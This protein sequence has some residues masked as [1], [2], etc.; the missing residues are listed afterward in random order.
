MVKDMGNLRGIPSKGRSGDR[1]GHCG[2]FPNTLVGLLGPVIPKEVSVQERTPGGEQAPRAQ[3]S[4]SFAPSS[5]AGVLPSP[6]GRPTWAERRLALVPSGEKELMKVSLGSVT[7][8]Y[9]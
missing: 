1:W 8:T 2:D 4:S 5:Q 9:K 3:S 6:P 7:I